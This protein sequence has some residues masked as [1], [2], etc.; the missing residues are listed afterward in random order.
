MKTKKTIATLFIVGG[1]TCV[2]HAEFGV[3]AGSSLNYKAKFRS[4]PAVQ[5]RATNPGAAVADTDH[6]YDDGYNLTDSSSTGVGVLDTTYW[7]YQNGSQYDPAGD[8]GNGTIRMNSSRTTIDSGSSSER[9][10]DMQP[11]LEVYWQTDLTQNKYWNFGVRAALRWQNIRIENS[12]VSGTTIDTISDTYS[13]N[14]S[15]PPG[16]PFTGVLD[17]WGYATLGDTPTRLQTSGAGPSVLATRELNANLFGL[18]VGPTVS[19]N[20]IENLSVAASAGGTVAWMQS[21]F[22]YS[23]GALARGSS[24]D[25][26]CLFGAY[27]GVD[28]K[29][30]FSE[31][32]GVF[33][34]AAYNLLQDFDQEYGGRSAELQFGSSYTVRTGIF[35]Q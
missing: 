1:L 33:V 3:S 6:Y 24:S 11:A 14:G 5:L 13:L 18:D 15:I 21:D 16:A 4:A 34:G 2:T 23:D 20:I 22:S 30:K 7:G 25:G 31:R 27:M 9:E 8:G 19:L 10:E 32:W 12:S 28:L 35:F 26:K 17:G 29:Y